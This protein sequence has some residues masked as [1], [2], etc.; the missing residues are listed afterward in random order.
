[1]TNLYSLMTEKVVVSLCRMI[2]PLIYHSPSKS[3]SILV[4]LVAVSW[5]ESK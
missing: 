4:I 3:I 5:E 2:D 1:M